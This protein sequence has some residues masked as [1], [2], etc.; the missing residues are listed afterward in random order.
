MQQNQQLP[1]SHSLFPP[2]PKVRGLYPTRA[3]AQ[4]SGRPPATKQAKVHS[5]AKINAEDQEMPKH[6]FKVTIFMEIEH[7][8]KREVHLPL[9]YVKCSSYRRVY[10]VL[11]CLKILNTKP[12][13]KYF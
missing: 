11:K 4:T 10:I 5:G 9:D 6:S 8:S 1:V 7:Q 3:C 13:T 2:R 12:T